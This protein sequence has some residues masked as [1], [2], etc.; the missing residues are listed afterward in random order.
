M[1]ELI[2]NHKHGLLD[3]VFDLFKA[4][5]VSCDPDYAASI[6]LSLLTVETLAPAY[7]HKRE[8]TDPFSWAARNLAEAKANKQKPIHGR[9]ALCD[10]ADA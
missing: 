6:G 9:M 4:E 1:D 8:A 3:V 2:R 7:F 10:P 5:L